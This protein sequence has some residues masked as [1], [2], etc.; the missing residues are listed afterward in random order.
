MRVIKRKKTQ[1]SIKLVNMKE[2]MLKLT[3]F[4][5]CGNINFLFLNIYNYLILKEVVK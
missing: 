2:K 4:T 1:N 5:F 3:S